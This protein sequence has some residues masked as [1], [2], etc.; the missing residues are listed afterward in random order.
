MDF[1]PKEL[2]WLVGAST[3][4]AGFLAHWAWD[5]WWHRKD[6][7]DDAHSKA[8]A[9]QFKDHGDRLTVVE[10]NQIANDAREME[11][12]RALGR[13]EGEQHRLDG[14]I[15]A[16]QSFWRTEFTKLVEKFGSFEEKI[17][18]RLDA[19]RLELREDQNTHEDRLTQMLNAHQTRVH[20]RLNAI[21]AE[22]A[23]MLNEVVDMLVERAGEPRP[24][25]TIPKVT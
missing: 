22:Q 12:Q 25:P 8:V 15:D 4:F 14:K 10:R 16:L 24:S 6:H 9:A 19:F 20:D 3:A 13:L 11:R 17:D 2:T 7:H 1:G 23:K 18:G 5:R 21:S